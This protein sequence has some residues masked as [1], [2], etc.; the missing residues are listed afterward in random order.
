MGAGGVTTLQTFFSWLRQTLCGWRGHDLLLRF[1]VDRVR[2]CCTSCPYLSEGWEV[3]PQR[4]VQKKVRRKNVVPIR[5][6]VTREKK[7][8]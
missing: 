4:P 8:A 1:E 5:A 3:S 6:V 2:L 7:C